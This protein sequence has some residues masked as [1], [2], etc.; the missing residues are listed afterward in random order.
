MQQHGCVEPAG[1]QS[2]D[3]SPQAAWP[4]VLAAP[5]RW[6]AIDPDD[7]AHGILGGEDLVGARARFGKQGDGS[8]GVTR[9]GAN[10][11]QMPDHVADAG[12]WLHD[13]QTMRTRGQALNSGYRRWPGVSFNRSGH[14]V[15]CG[16][17]PVRLG[18]RVPCASL[19]ARASQNSRPDLPGRR[20]PALL[21]RAP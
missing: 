15:G 16:S 14:A 20:L 6:I 7:F 10:V 13:E 19:V 11:R 8:A 4:I 12:Q 18:L 1:A 5:M 3:Q 9:Q 21:T 17:L 2:V